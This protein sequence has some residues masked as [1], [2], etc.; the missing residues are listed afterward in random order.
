MLGWDAIYLC[1]FVPLPFNLIFISFFFFIFFCV[2]HQ[3]ELKRGSD[4]SNWFIISAFIRTNEM[5]THFGMASV[6]MKSFHWKRS[7]VHSIS[8]NLNNSIKTERAHSSLDS[9]L[10]FDDVVVNLEHK[11]TINT[12]KWVRFNLFR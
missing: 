9:S 11:I 6:R 7:K 3:F 8:A 4:S 12:L 1:F 5:M 2:N 10:I